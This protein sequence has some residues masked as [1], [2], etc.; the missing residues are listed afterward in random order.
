[1]ESKI[2]NIQGAGFKNGWH[3]FEI[4]MEDGTIAKKGFKTQEHGLYVCQEVT[5]SMNES[6]PN[7]FKSITAKGQ[8][9]KSQNNEMIELLAC[10]KVIGSI[11]SGSGMSEDE[12]AEKTQALLNQLKTK[13]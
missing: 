1:M 8:K 12:I 9:P 13:L 11:Y 10:A 5:Y 2:K 6:Y 3:N 7:L 4:E